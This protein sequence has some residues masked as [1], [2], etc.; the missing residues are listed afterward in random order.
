[1][2]KKALPFVDLDVL[3]AVMLSRSS[4]VN[5]VSNALL[6][7]AVAV[8]WGYVLYAGAVASKRYLDSIDLSQFAKDERVPEFLEKIDI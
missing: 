8:S 2:T 5:L 7:A 1:M 6:L 3:I 4:A